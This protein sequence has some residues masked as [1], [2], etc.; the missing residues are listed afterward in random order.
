MLNC[1]IDMAVR[2]AREAGHADMPVIGVRII[3]SGIA[4]IEPN[5]VPMHSLIFC[6]V[7]CEYPVGC[8]NALSPDLNRR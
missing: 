2:A 7:Q 4:G 6:E 5:E 1:F 8:Y 3:P